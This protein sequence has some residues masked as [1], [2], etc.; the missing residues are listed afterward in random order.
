M[1]IKPVSDAAVKSTRYL[2]SDEARASLARDPYWPKWHSPW[3]H[4]TLLWE[5]GDARLIPKTIVA[6]MVAKLKTHYLP[7]FPT[8]QAAVPAGTDL[9][10][11]VAC[12]CAVGTMHQVLSACGIDVEAELPWLTKWLLKYQL[13]DGGLNCDAAAYGGSNKSSFL[14][15]VVAMEAVM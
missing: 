10:R 12:H 13:P 15:T 4:M 1:T 9:Y 3:W 14:S 7:F 11:D 6:A 8:N 2:D 5:L